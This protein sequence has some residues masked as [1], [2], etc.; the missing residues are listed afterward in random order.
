M[1][2]EEIEKWE[3]KAKEGILRNDDE[4]RA[5]VEDIQ[6]MFWRCRYYYCFKKTGY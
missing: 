5:F 1:T 4:L 6:S 3:K 2:T